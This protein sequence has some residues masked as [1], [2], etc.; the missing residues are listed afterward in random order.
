MWRSHGWEPI[1]SERW[2]TTSHEGIG[3]ESFF[4]S[5]RSRLTED[6]R[7]GHSTS[8]I[9]PFWEPTLELKGYPFRVW[10]QDLDVWAAGTEL[11]QEQQAPAVVQRLGGAARELARGVPTTQLRDGRV[12]PVTGVTTTGLTMLV[13]GLERRFGQFAVETSTRCIIPLT[14]FPEKNGI[15]YIWFP[16]LKSK[17]NWQ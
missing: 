4:K 12:D 5:G 16:N 1:P 9:P 15:L 13:Q 17:G 10:L 2:Y 8:K 6:D 11:Q 7:I 14:C 3:Y